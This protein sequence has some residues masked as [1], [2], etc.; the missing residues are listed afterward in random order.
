MHVA[1]PPLSTTT[2]SS[3]LCRAGGIYGDAVSGLSGGV[4]SL[5]DQDRSA[6]RGKPGQR[7]VETGAAKDGT[8]EDLVEGRFLSLRAQETAN[9]T[10]QER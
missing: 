5:A 4:L 3:S 2:F 6:A 10:L 8:A 1:S 7:A 9:H